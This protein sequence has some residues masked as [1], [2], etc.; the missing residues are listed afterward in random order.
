M[1]VA[2]V[3]SAAS[4][5]LMRVWLEEVDP[6]WHHVVLAPEGLEPLEAGARAPQFR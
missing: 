5:S 4:R 3:L 2:V 1:S 6:G